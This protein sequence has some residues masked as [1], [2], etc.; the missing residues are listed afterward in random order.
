MADDTTIVA[1]FEKETLPGRTEVIEAKQEVLIS[2]PPATSAAPEC[3]FR[4]DARTRNQ[5]SGRAV[6]VRARNG[7]WG[8][9]HLPGDQ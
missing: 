7:I 9:S 8:A 3:A 1:A 4:G 2:Q 5:N 6:L